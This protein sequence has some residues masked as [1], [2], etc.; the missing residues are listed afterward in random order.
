MALGT[1]YFLTG[2]FQEAI[3]P[4]HVHSTEYGFFHQEHRFQVPDS[5]YQVPGARYQMCRFQVPGARFKIPEICK[6]LK[7]LE[8]ILN[9]PLTNIY[10]GNLQYPSLQIS[11]FGFQTILLEKLSCSVNHG[12]LNVFV[13]WYTPATHIFFG[14]FTGLNMQQIYPCWS[15]AVVQIAFWHGYLQGSTNL[16]FACTDFC[17][18]KAV[19]VGT[20]LHC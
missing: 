8:L 1:Q 17:V 10:V 2:H 20:S 18:H 14:V 7:L 19:T 16:T 4:E 11:V 13:N 12:G 5:R 15:D 6:I 9:N 3:L